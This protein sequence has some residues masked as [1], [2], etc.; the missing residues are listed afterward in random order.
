MYPVK[1]HRATSV[2]EAKAA[3]TSASEA[4]FL[5]GGQTLLPTMKQHLAAPSDLIDLRGIPDL[6]GISADGDG[7]RVGAMTT[8]AEVAQ[9]AEVKE[10]IPVLAHMAST[11]GDSAVRHLGTMGGSLANND[12]AADYPAAVLGLNATVVTDRREI[13]AE[14]YFQGLFATAL[15][16]GEMIVAVR[17]PRPERA[18]YAK[19][20]NPASR[21]PMV[22]VLVAKTGGGVRVAVTGTGQDGVFRHQGLEQALSSDWSQ[23]AVDGVEI[24]EEGLMND[25]HASAD[26]RA[27]L[28]RVMA[29]RAVA[30]S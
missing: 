12:V 6:A 14:D 2:D 19:Q 28:I 18:G 16:E 22:G 7:V 30:A 25:I 5:A 26:Y 9:S 21:Y 23:G 1:Y 11:I 10:A 15:E 3:F 29:K 17:Y 13:A 24:G 27:H 8:H 4:R 20:T